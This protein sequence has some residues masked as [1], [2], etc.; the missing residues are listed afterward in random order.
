MAS[1]APDEPEYSSTRESARI[2]DTLFA[3]VDAVS[4]P[5]EAQAK[6]ADIV[7][8]AERDE[9]YLPIPFKESEVTAALKAVEASLAALLADDGAEPPAR[10]RIAISHEKTTAFLFQA[11]LA[12]IDGLGKLD[13]GVKAL[14]KDTDLLEAQSDPYRRMSANLYATADEG[15]YYHIHGSL[16]AST[17][18]RM[19]GLEPR[20]PD[21]RTHSDIV[22]VIEAA[23]R[24][25]SVEQL[26]ALNA[27]HRQAGV[28]AFKHDDFLRTPHV[29]GRPWLGRAAG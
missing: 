6:K 21:L 20:R 7:F 18:L 16:E 17:T 4:L 5:P 3:L 15:E 13:P 29:R 11:Y 12:E 8:H 1:V 9:P 10:R 28:K 2:F 22:G 26:E 14:L 19:L 24:T 27:Q 23:V 25:H